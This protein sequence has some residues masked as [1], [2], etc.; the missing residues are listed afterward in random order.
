MNANAH[1]LRSAHF[2][3]NWEAWICLQHFLPSHFLRELLVHVVQQ[4]SSGTL[5][6]KDLFVDSLT[7]T[8]SELEIWAAHPKLANSDLGYNLQLQIRALMWMNDLLIDSSPGDS[9]SPANRALTAALKLGQMD[10]SADPRY[11]QRLQGQARQDT[12]NHVIN[13]IRT[14]LE[15]TPNEREQSPFELIKEHI[16]LLPAPLDMLLLKHAGDLLADADSWGGA[17][18]LYSMAFSFLDRTPSLWDDLASSV[19]S[20][21]VQSI[22]AANY[23]L[24][25]AEH[26]EE[27][28]N[29]HLRNEDL[30]SNPLL[31]CNA[32]ADALMAGY[33]R[34]PPSSAPD[35][36]P[37]VMLPPLLIESHCVGD[38]LRADVNG[39]DEVAHRLFWATLR[40]QFAL[41]SS[42][43]RKETQRLYATSLLKSLEKNP[44]GELF[45]MGCSL[46]IDSGDS[47]IIEKISWSEDVVTRFVNID[48]VALVKRKQTAYPKVS[49]ERGRVVAALFKEWLLVID[50]QQRDIADQMLSE[51]AR[52]AKHGDSS[53]YAW[54]DLLSPCI[55]VLK[56]I[57]KRRPEFAEIAARHVVEITLDVLKSTEARFWTATSRTLEVT[58]LYL[59]YFETTAQREILTAV[60]DLLRK[61]DGDVM[62]PIMDPA[63]SIL[64]SDAAYR[65][66]E[67]DDE[68]GMAIVNTLVEYGSQ[69]E[70]E[71]AQFLANFQYFPPRLLNSQKVRARLDAVIESVNAGLSSRSSIAIGKIQS[72]LLVPSLVGL[73]RVCN[74]VQALN[75][76]LAPVITP[77]YHHFIPE[78]YLPL[79]VLAHQFNTEKLPTDGRLREQC[80]S[81]FSTLTGIWNAAMQKPHIM[82][83]F[84]IPQR[85]Q[86]EDAIVHNW[87]LT[88]LELGGALHVKDLAVDVLN[89]ARNVDQLNP[90]ITM[91]FAT[92]WAGRSMEGFIEFD[93][94][95]I[96][97]TTKDAFYTSLGRYL[98]GISSSSEAAV[99]LVDVLLDQVIKFGPRDADIGVL[100]AAFQLGVTIKEKKNSFANYKQRALADSRIRTLLQPVI[101]QLERNDSVM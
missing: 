47:K 8:P 7:G 100:L 96:R 42:G 23:V 82:A 49:I 26:A 57:A 66:C 40:R 95:Q 97:T 74:A 18:S 81:L 41:G 76:L 45:R 11:V 86:A 43:E 94:D 50:A 78:T 13:A 44:S 84:S 27:S 36:R 51:I 25:G 4:V 28:L 39:N 73:E 85:G 14:L 31:L 80:L 2:S 32:T 77:P 52:L 93:L 91:A 19:R 17:S 53:F 3:Q 92:L 34:V 70:R 35:R 6:L 62:W 33:R 22:A 63:L 99:K 71:Q 10:L 1:S 15:G 56:E 12:F 21:L 72:F 58:Q 55:A 90:G 69:R 20:V 60:V 98:I 16:S 46:L 101:S 83:S 48:L 75:D 24:N 88:T 54:A 89:G 67:E 79:R 64:Y 38:A 68:L 30:H 29:E 9:Q 61:F 65:A 37:A 59:N 87:A 5:E